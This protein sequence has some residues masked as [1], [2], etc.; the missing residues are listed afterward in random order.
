MMA[1]SQA[2]ETAAPPVTAVSEEISTEVDTVEAT[3]ELPPATAVPESEGDMEPT[4]VVESEPEPTTENGNGR[5]S[6]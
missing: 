6:D 2:E 3:A 5:S 1:C 4:A